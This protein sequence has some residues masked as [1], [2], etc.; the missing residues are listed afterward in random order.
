MP[1][2]LHNDILTSG[3]SDTEIKAYLDNALKYCDILTLAVWT[4]AAGQYS[5]SSLRGTFSNYKLQTTNYKCGLKFAVEDMGFLEDG[6]IHEFFNLPVIYA[7]LVW[8]NENKFGG[9]AF[10][11]AG[12]TEKG[13][14]V[15]KLFNSSNIAADFAHMNKKT[16]Y[17]AA[18]LY[19]KPI[20]CSHT[21]FQSCVPKNAPLN[22]IANARNLDDGQI[23]L[24]V[25][26]GGLIGLTFVATFL[27]GTPECSSGDIARHIDWFVQ[28]HG[29]K[30]LAIGTDYYGT[31]ELPRDVSDYKDFNVLADKLSRLGYPAEA[32]SSIF[33]GNYKRFVNIPFVVL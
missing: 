33:S 6:D 21:C 13:R 30:N 29:F 14:A 12:L 10:S 7:G 4:A 8:N 19:R 16:F 11:D 27:N 24:I 32:V 25:Q 1:C 28:K 15:I 18:E 17:E 26:S 23:K 20:L 5:V 31:K 22:H 3:L 9:G 2:D